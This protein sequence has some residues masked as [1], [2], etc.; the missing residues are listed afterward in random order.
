VGP[1]GFYAPPPTNPNG[2]P[3]LFPP[4]AVVQPR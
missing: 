4:P 1:P 2:F 3:N